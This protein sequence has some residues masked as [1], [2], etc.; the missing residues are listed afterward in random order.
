MKLYLNEYPRAFI[1]VS[2]QYALIVRHPYPL[3]KY[4]HHHHH[5]H[6]HHHHEQ[7]T[8]DSS[9]S[10]SSKV[11][12]EFVRKDSLNLSKYVDLT[13]AKGRAQNLSGFL[14]LLNVKD[15]LY[16][17]FVSSAVTV[18]TPRIDED[19]QKITGVEVFCLNSDE[20]D[21]QFLKQIHTPVSSGTEDDYFELQSTDDKLLLTAGSVPSVRKLLSLGS[22]FFSHQFD[23]TSTIQERGFRDMQLPKFSLMGDLPYQRQFMWNSFLVSE[24]IEFRGR[25]TPYEQTCFDS[26]GFLITITRGYAKTVNSTLGNGEEVLLTLISKQACAKNGPLFG[27][28]GSD[29]N[30]HV[31][32]FAESELV[33]FGSK[34]CLTYIMVRG[35]VPILWSLETHISKRTL[36]AKKNKKVVFPRSFE[37][38]Q[39]AFTKH[40]DLLSN[41]YGDIHILNALS[42]DT[43]TYKGK[44]NITFKEHIKYFLEHRGNDE[45]T[46]TNYKLGY[47][48]MP[49][50]TSSMKKAD[51][52]A[53]NPHEFSQPIAKLV[54]N[55]GAL[56]YD[57][58]SRTYVGKQLGVFRVNS[59]DSLS[60]ASF[61]CKII[62]Q[63]VI[64]LAMRDL[65]IDA[66]HDL[67][68]KHA[69]LWAETDEYLRNITVNFVSYTDK[70]HSSSA[71]SKGIVPSQLKKRYM[72]TVLDHK[73]GE[74]AILKLLG[75]LQD[76]VSVSL[77]NPLH[78]YVTKELE[79]REKEFTSQRDI[80]VFA[81]T[82]NV[83]AS[84]EDQ[85]KFKS[86]L[87]PPGSSG[88][89]D[90]VF[91]GLQEIVELTAS[92]MV[93]TDTL[94]R[95]MWEMHLRVCLET[96]NTTQSRYILL[97]SG[98]LGGIAL[99]LFVKQLEL[100]EIHDVEGSFKKTGF[101]GVSANKG[102]VAVRFNYS[103]TG[104][105]LVA[106][107]FAAG[108][109]NTME[110]HQNFKTIGKG[111]K[112][113]KNRRIKDH[114]AVIWL[115][116]FNY[117]INL[118]LEQVH[119]LVEKKDFPRL[120]EYDQLNQQMASGESFP[121]FDEMELRFK[122]TY[123]FDNGTSTYDTSEKQRI[124]AWTDRILC[125]S[126]KKIIKQHLYDCSDEIKF[127]DHRPVYAVLSVS[128]SVVNET[129]KKNLTHELYENYRKNY[130][131]INDMIVTNTNLSFLISEADD[132]VLP[133]PSSDTT[134]WWL[135]NGRLAKI[136]IPELSGP[137]ADQLVFNPKYPHN[138][139]QETEEP[140]FILRSQLAQ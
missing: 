52:T 27:D 86:W 112:F 39:V 46:A 134:K 132:N 12:V 8:S 124:P 5:H 140:E 88:D 36:A 43:K 64:Q 37:A 14:G 120:F 26:C 56:F 57:I 55:F 87:F 62:S 11:I 130:G 40:L 67:L 44:L 6:L 9:K 18:A 60:K 15:K 128:I 51:Y 38:S 133:P 63:E 10:K 85:D 54:L 123:K 31:S 111:I 7:V 24:L 106:S 115:G 121:Y 29:D 127:S 138:P 75:A 99:F 89:Y 81:S 139:F 129:V 16:L 30:G 119:A 79:R 58:D 101:G 22:F 72:H 20:F 98:Q 80:L 28:W 93:D 47:T 109:G 68:S 114:D 19:V 76:Q 125:L 25:L 104:L 117:R 107:H 90:L 102:A 65:G 74:M 70:L 82:F 83:N 4:H 53:V 103:N 135:S 45:Q 105:C 49:V 69:R 34:F 84:C 73:P 131:D 21:W 116:D 122:P 66:G 23:V 96:N 94:R 100:K 118:P 95:Q 1:L 33:L 126:R 50:A 41:Q 110:R 136:T 137:N 3:Y 113:S 77:H 108:H 92:Q 97:W 71:A 78:D 35:N 17:V 91:I 2:D 59:F 61:L 13:A 48:D 32:N 42:Q